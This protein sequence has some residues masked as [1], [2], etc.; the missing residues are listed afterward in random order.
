MIISPRVISED[1]PDRSSLARLFLAP[2]FQNKRGEDL[3]V[4]IW[5]FVVDGD[6]G[7]YHYFPPHERAGGHFVFDPLRLLNVFGFTICGIHANLLGCLFLAAGF[8]NARICNLKGHEATEVYYDNGWHLFDADLQAFHRCHPPQEGRIAS[9]EECIAD[10]TLISQQKN[11]SSPYY[12]PD[13]PPEKMA[14][15]YR[16]KPSYS[17]IYFIKLHTM[18]FCL[19]PGE[20]IERYWHN[21][22]RWINFTAYGEYNRNYPS[23]WCP[24]GPR[25]HFAPHRTYGNGKLVYK[26]DLTANSRD[27]QAGAREMSNVT[28]TGE[29]VF[30]DKAGAG[31]LIFEFDSPYPFA[32]VPDAEQKAPPK[33]GTVLR[34]SIVRKG[35]RD[36]ARIL[37][38]VAPEE[39]QF[40][41]WEREGKGEDEVCIDLTTYTDNSYRYALKFEFYS[42]EDS[43]GIRS[44]EVES[45]FFLA[46]P[47]LPALHEG[48]NRLRVAFGDERGQLKRR[49]V[50][51]VDLAAQED[52]ESK[53]YASSNLIY[54]RDMPEIMRPEKDG[55]YTLTCLVK[56]PP[57]G[58]LTRLYV[59]GLFQYALVGKQRDDMVG[60]E[61]SEDDG[62]TWRTVFAKPVEFFRER[63]H[64][65]GD[66]EIE[67]SSP[68]KSCL[69]RF[70]ARTGMKEIKIRA[71]Y[72]DARVDDFKL[73]L[74]I[75]HL[76]REKGEEMRHTEKINPYR[77][78]GYK[79]VCGK[80]PENIGIIME[81]YTAP[82][83]SGC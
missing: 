70:R 29:G 5:R 37:I 31:S 58:L 18:D 4:A 38:S 42:E 57:H 27:V 51:E 80:D 40:L 49:F 41:L 20:R 81:V 45:W 72:I 68:R 65:S 77:D 64:F 79:V 75:T 56:A 54:A 66:G 83:L 1:V 76:W 47:S 33:D 55:D 16:L 82:P 78:K 50:T 69:V 12:L 10:P 8:E 36:K 24:Q 74:C 25:Q 7:L 63:W 22:G 30:L 46:P 9:Y 62:A 39:R 52:Y 21:Q 2:Q 6:V 34:A 14:E 59:L 61:I 11:P 23:E 17:D 19:R 44:M 73:P 15:L 13:K 67:L 43:V 3:A 71:H 35:A 48:E 53:I 28:V 26:P 60:A 32:G